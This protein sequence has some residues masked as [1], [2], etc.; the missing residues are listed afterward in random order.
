MSKADLA[1]CE[2]RK[3]SAEQ[4]DDAG[5]GEPLFVGNFQPALSDFG[6]LKLYWPRASIYELLRVIGITRAR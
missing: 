6:N 5:P 2:S 3:R 1:W 4:F